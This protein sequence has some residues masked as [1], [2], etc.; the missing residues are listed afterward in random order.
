MEERI[1]SFGFQLIGRQGNM[2]RTL[3][4]YLG[5]QACFEE[6]LWSGEAASSSFVDT[7]LPDVLQ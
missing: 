6:Q 7:N 2:L 1:E 5:F 3:Q 4:A